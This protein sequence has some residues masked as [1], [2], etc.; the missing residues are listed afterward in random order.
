[1][2]PPLATLKKSLKSEHVLSAAWQVPELYM[3]LCA[4][5]V[6]GK[7]LRQVSLSPLPLEQ[8][9]LLVEMQNGGK[10]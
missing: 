1:M 6:L 4:G 10:S 9:S 8:S 5:N 7:I 2:T 3:H